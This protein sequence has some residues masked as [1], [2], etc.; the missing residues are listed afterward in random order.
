MSL[1]RI[2]DVIR[3]RPCLTGGL[4]AI[5]GAAA[6]PSLPLQSTGHVLAGIGQGSDMHWPAGHGQH[7]R[8]G[9]QHSDVVSSFL[10]P[11][12]LCVALLSLGSGCRESH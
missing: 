3:G 7:G 2:V 12:W 9:V 10:A 11:T 6:I 8:P 4:I 5:T 1:P